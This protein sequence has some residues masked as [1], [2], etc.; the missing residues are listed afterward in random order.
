[1]TAKP[2]I[3]IA[4]RSSELALWQSN[5]VADALA[6]MIDGAKLELVPIT[7]T[8]D[9]ILDMPLA[10][11]GGKGLFIKELEV[12]LMEERADIAVHSM[13]DVPAELPEGLHIPAVLPREDPRDVL[14]S[15]EGGT[16]DDL[17]P[18]ARVGTSSLRRKSQLLA[19]R[20]D[21][22]V[23]DLRGNVPTRMNKLADGAFD[24]IVLAA[25]GLR[26]L[27][28]LDDHH[29]LVDTGLML[30][31]V[32]QGVIGLECRA[33]DAEVEGLIGRLNHEPTALCL[34]AERSMNLRL[35]GDCSVPVAGYARIDDGELVLTGL[36]AGVDGRR[37]VRHTASGPPEDAERIGV[38]LGER[39][40][41][42]GA[43]QILKDLKDA[44]EK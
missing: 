35:G 33:G 20:G 38:G 2:V 13:K 4:T 23:R 34:R 32:G 9:R 41:N 24:A 28:L 7:T 16:L 3:R 8:G 1:M 27:G 21:L 30:P 6:S 14:V 12:A 5:H 43:D 44:A 31:A 25:A 18:G 17:P 37:V 39:L 22:E 19:A 26:R 42:A 10:R 11:I 36:V 29:H 15:V 40:L